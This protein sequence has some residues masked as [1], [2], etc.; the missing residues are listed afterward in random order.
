MTLQLRDAG[1]ADGP[2]IRTLLIHAFGGPAEAKL[3]E[4]LCSTGDLMASLVAVEA[5]RI[6][7]HV[8]LSPLRSPERALAL[9]PLAVSADQRRR[10]IGAALVRAAI[11]RGRELAAPTLF[12]LGEPRYY[13]RFGF[14]AEAAAPYPC[15]HAGPHFMALH[16]TA[17]PPP[18]APAV[19]AD[20]FAAV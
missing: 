18:P 20:A 5:G 3:V 11:D 14:T 2:A 13:G 17:A 19:Y 8:A 16:L 4:A 1:P 10:G 12:V 6:V 7:G 15:C 9:A